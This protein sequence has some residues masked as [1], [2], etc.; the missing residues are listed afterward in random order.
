MSDKWEESARKHAE[1]YVVSQECPTPPFGTALFI[2]IHP[3]VEPLFLGV[4]PTERRGELLGRA[5]A[6]LAHLIRQLED[7]RREAGAGEDW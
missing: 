1:A 4:E 5:V 7:E 6:H 3:D 2:K